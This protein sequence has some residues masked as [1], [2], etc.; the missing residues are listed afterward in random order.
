MTTA[1][2]VLII[3]LNLICLNL[4]FQARFHVFDWPYTFSELRL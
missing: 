3:D 1:L 2:H 4:S